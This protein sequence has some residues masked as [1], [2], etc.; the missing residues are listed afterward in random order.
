MPDPG[1]VPPPTLGRCA[2]VQRPI[3]RRRR[4]RAA[5]DH[6]RRHGPPA[7]GLG[8]DVS[9]LEVPSR[10][11]L[12]K[13]GRQVVGEVVE[14]G[15]WSIRDAAAARA[16]ASSESSGPAVRSTDR[17]RGGPS[18]AGR[19]APSGSRPPP[20]PRRA[21]RGGTPVRAGSSSHARRPAGCSSNRWAG[22]PARRVGEGGHQGRVRWRAAGPTAPRSRC[23]GC[24]RSWQ[25]IRRRRTSWRRRG[26]T[27]ASTLTCTDAV[28]H[29]ID[30]AGRAPGVEVPLHRDVPG[31]VGD[32]VRP[33]GS[34]R[35]RPR[36][37]G[38]H[39][40][41]ARRRSAARSRADGVD[42]VREIGPGRE[43]S[44]TCPPGSTVSCRHRGHHSRRR[45]RRNSAG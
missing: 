45:V 14:G 16:A 34:G 7:A 26:A 29:I 20:H 12:R 18:S 36:P 22:P 3:G 17:C 15:R 23:S 42:G 40:R 44:S 28:E 39:A 4:R 30:A 9:D 41:A 5:R 38:R 1:R 32:P 43:L 19:R 13:Q 35:R 6:R 37:A 8:V 21:G 33:A 31:L 27:P 25:S 11:D 10:P 2:G 24:R